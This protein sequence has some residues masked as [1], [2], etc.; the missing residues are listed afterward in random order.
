[1]SVNKWN[2]WNSYKKK[3]YGNEMKKLLLKMWGIKKKWKIS[4]CKNLYCLVRKRGGR[5]C[6]RN[7]SF[8]WQNKKI[9]IIYTKVNENG[10][11]VGKCW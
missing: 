1:V 3:A 11:N 7:K 6:G 8:L 2:K 5:N 10:I 4:E 9:I